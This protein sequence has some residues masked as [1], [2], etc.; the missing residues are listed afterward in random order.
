LQQG[1]REGL[2]NKQWKDNA[3]F[4][5][6]DAFGPSHFAR[7]AGW[8]E[9]SLYSSGRVAPWPLAWDGAS[10]S[11]YVFNWSSITDYTVFSPQI[12][13]M[14]WV[15][16]L[17]EAQ[18]LN[19]KFWFEI[20]TWDGHEQGDSDKRKAY[21]KA[22]Q[23]YN[24][25]RYGGMVQFG[26]WLLRPRVVREFRAY[27]DILAQA[28]PYF[29]PIVN[30]VDRVHQNAT[31]RDFWR[32]GELVPNRSHPH[33]YQTIVPREY[34]SA[35]RWFLLDTSLDPKRPWELGTPIPVFSLALVKGNAPQRQWLV[36]AHSP[37]GPRQGVQIT[38]PGYRAVTVNV[39]IG[40]SFY[41]IDEK[42]QRV[43]QI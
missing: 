38:I 24:P 42:G 20:S 37:L 14:N 29:L 34:Q 21:A 18:K 10:P 30:A 4:I 40:G 31:L 15:F 1:I 13:T 36:Y 35:D 17:K 39:S 12:E 26:M 41:L 5:A 22:G 8:M 16:M 23:Q 3:V 9:H 33:P 32:K 28:E 27:Q 7:W 19:P 6:Y 25:E 2:S 11:F 43:Q